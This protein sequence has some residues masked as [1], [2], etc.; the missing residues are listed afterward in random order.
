MEKIRVK[1]RAK[2]YFTIYS[3][4]WKGGL[5]L[6]WFNGLE[7]EIVNF[8]NYHI[9]IKFRDESLEL[10]GYVTRFCGMPKTVRRVE[11]W[12]L[13]GKINTIS[14]TCWYVLD[15]FNKITT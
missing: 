2:F 14:D 1:I 3:I 5:A 7:L 9:H 8:S 12:N 15:D 10:G 6:M 11:S 4:G 13:L